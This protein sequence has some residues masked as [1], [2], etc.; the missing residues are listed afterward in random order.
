M[1]DPNVYEVGRVEPEGE[2]P[3]IVGVDYE[4]VS[5]KGDV[6]L[7]AGEQEEFA[8]LYVHACHLAGRAAERLQAEADYDWRHENDTDAQ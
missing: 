2:P 7:S 5:L 6:T 3:L 1:A 4:E 8:Q